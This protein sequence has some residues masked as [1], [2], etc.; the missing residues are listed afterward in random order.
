MDRRA[1]SRRSLTF[2]RRK[3]D[4]SGV[5][6]AAS[7]CS[8]D[9]TRTACFN[10]LKNG[11]LKASHARCTDATQAGVGAADADEA[12]VLACVA[13]CAATVVALAEA[14]A[15]RPAAVARSG[16]DT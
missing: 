9:V 5:I 16:T 2:S 8:I 6:S 15:A 11:T 14:A 4:W 12:A 7:G 10:S 1:L 3:K 13:A